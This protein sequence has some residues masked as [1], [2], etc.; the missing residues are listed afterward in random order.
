VFKK[1]AGALKSLLPQS[2]YKKGNLVINKPSVSK[3]IYVYFF[4]VLFVIAYDLSISRAATLHVGP[5]QTYTS[6]G[7]A[8]TA[9]SGGDIINIHA[10]TYHEYGLT[11]KSG[12]AVAFTIIRANPG[13]S[14]IID[15][16]LGTTQNTPIFILDGAYI[17]I[18]GLHI[19]GGGDGNNGP[20]TVGFNGAGSY[21]VIDSNTIYDNN[22]GCSN[23]DTNNASNIT[24]SH[25]D[26]VT[27]S[28]NEIYGN[29]TRGIVMDT[30][31]GHMTH[32]TITNNF[33]HDVEM[34][35]NVKWA[36]TSSDT[37]VTIQ[38]N[39]IQNMD[40]THSVAHAVGLAID[41]DY[42]LIQDNI[43]DTGEFAMWFGDNWYGGHGTV[44]HNT[45]YGFTKSTYNGGTGS[46][47]TF[48][49]NI[50]YNA[51]TIEDY[52]SG[53][54]YSDYTSNPDFANSAG[55]DFTLQAGSGAIGAA[56]DGTN[57]GADISAVGIRQVKIRETD[58]VYSS[59]SDA[60]SV[61]DD[62]NTILMR[63]MAYDDILNLSRDLSIVLEGGYDSSFTYRTGFT[64][65][66]G[67]MTISKGTVTVE[68][69]ILK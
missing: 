26:H 14:P 20:L 23:V 2:K 1:A 58:V 38:Y 40:A 11:P 21:I 49:D 66:S 50:R 42:V 5:G 60:Y 33:I 61:A 3:I 18:M 15:A 45:I 46:N 69:L 44:K 53:N 57:Y 59:I 62:S 64:S 68:K 41:Q 67:N 10:G 48:I 34:G 39:R 27:I 63:A 56:S 51:S 37:H 24:L 43:L 16:Q 47:I 25:G 65:L 22:V 13:D 54:T 8:I 30:R 29:C 28:N 19:T 7:A 9:S 55:H 36:D 32:V 12:S 31:S 17:K 6:I 35:V 52:G 4:A